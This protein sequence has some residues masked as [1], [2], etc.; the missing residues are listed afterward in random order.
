M[1]PR[2]LLL[3]LVVLALIGGLWLYDALVW[4]AFQVLLDW[5]A[6]SG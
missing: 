2:F 3:G 1:S 4:H 6:G 5:L